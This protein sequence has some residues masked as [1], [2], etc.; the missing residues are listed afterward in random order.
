VTLTGFRG[1]VGPLLGW[2]VKSW[3]GWTAAF[4]LAFFLLLLASILM[5][6]QGKQ[7]D[8]AGADSDTR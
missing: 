8:A 6:Q 7:L 1:M 2:L 4:A 3:L 5:A